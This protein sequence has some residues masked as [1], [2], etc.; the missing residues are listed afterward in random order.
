MDDFEKWFTSFL[1]R[2]T[3]SNIDR[4]GLPYGTFIKRIAQAAF[5]AG[6]HLLMEGVPIKC[7]PCEYLMTPKPATCMRG[8]GFDKYCKYSE[9][10]ERAVLNHTTQGLVAP[11]A[12][13]TSDPN[14]EN[15]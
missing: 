14:C 7:A 9:T 11:V 6:K 4:E 5:D 15:K 3:L 13:A 1:T 2:E 12:S 10:E 8:S